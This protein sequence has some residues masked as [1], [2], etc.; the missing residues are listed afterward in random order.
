MSVLIV[1]AI[2]VLGGRW[3]WRIV[4][5]LFGIVDEMATWAVGAKADGVESAAQFRLVFGVTDETA[6]LVKSVSKLA[7]VAI[8]AGSILFVRSAQLRL[9]AAGIGLLLLID[10]LLLLGQLGRSIDH[11][12]A[13]APVQFAVTASMQL[14]HQS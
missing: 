14:H 5:S 4:A 2:V 11:R 13:V 10:L 1:V 7:F 3:W 8:F 6:K 9:V 12:L